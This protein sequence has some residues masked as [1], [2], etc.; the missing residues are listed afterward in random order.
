MKISRVEAIVAGRAPRTWLFVEIETDDG[1]VGVGEASQSRLD[2]GVVAAVANI[3]ADLVGSSPLGLI[4][5]RASAL[6]ANPFA[7]RIG[8]AAESAIE[9]ALW[10]LTGQALGVPVSTL[11]GGAVRDRVRLYANVSLAAHG[12]APDH[13][14]EAAARAAAD[15]FTAVKIYPLGTS[16]SLGST[17]PRQ[18][19]DHAVA[20]VRE[21]RA[22]VGPDVDVLTDWAWSATP[23]EARSLAERL[24]PYDLYWIEEPFDGTDPAALAEL[25][26]VLRVR[27]AA[28]EQLC[29]SRALRPLLENRAVDVVMPDVKWVGG[30]LEARKIAHMAEVFDIEVSPH[31]MSGPV[32]HAAS[33][34]LA[35]VSSRC[36]L[37]EYCYGSRPWR[38]DLV[39]G[40]E[41]IE[42]GYA[43][44]PTDPGL[45]LRW[46]PAV[47]RAHATA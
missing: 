15:G 34:H 27:L 35:A 6:A 8:Y 7:S 37:M 40:A 2:A 5:P 1:L 12:T 17:T 42:G 41:R 22:A 9:Q 39:G 18:A 33:L 20:V 28:G 4:E 10:D 46:D 13:W 43:V 24:A 44:V 11:L 23:G 47:A 38:H 16:R 32:N 31:S 30:I 19:A 45:G 29:G 26:R 21:V 14:A 3:G 36:D 25:K